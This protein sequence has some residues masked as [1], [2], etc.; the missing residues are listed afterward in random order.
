[1]NIKSHYFYKTKKQL[2][3]S[4]VILMLNIVLGLGLYFEKDI[5]LNSLTLSLVF[6]PFFAIVFFSPL[7]LLESL[8]LS[9]KYF[10][11]YLIYSNRAKN[12]F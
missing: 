12:V 9:I 1:M 2:N 7:I 10:S 8:Y 11:F 5:L 3:Y 6:I 4:L